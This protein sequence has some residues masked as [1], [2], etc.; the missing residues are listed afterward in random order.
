MRLD[1]RVER[2]ALNQLHRIE[3]DAVMQ[4]AVVYARDVGM[5]KPRSEL[6]LAIKSST[7]GFG[8]GCN[9]HQLQ[10]D[11]SSRAELYRAPDATHAAF[12]DAIFNFVALKL[13]FVICGDGL[14][15]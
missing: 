5:L 10:R 7:R 4:S 9:V 2:L 8:I 11:L 1:V 14:E 12:T 6:D 15:A 3:V 13:R